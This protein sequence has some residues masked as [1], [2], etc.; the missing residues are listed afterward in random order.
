MSLRDLLYRCA[1]CGADTGMEAETVH[2]KGCGRTY[3]RRVDGDGIRVVEPGGREATASYGEIVERIATIPGESGAISTPAIARF[4]EA[5]HPVR[6]RRE[7]LGFFEEWGPGVSGRLVM[8][9]VS[10]RFEPDEGEL[11]EW[12]LRD[13]R[14]LQTASSAIQISPR[15]GT[16]V[17]FRLLRDSPRRWEKLLKEQLRKVWHSEDRGEIIEFQPRIR[18]G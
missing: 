4:S 16:L 9:D 18:S 15:G 11:H 1:Y 5:E 3:S 7:L 13:L 14:A 10:L 12:A 6:F 17:S 8:D 2:C